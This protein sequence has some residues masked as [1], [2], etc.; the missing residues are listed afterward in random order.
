MTSAARTASLTAE[1]AADRRIRLGRRWTDL[2]RASFLDVDD[3]GVI[4]YHRD[5]S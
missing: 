3:D 2:P 4:T 1:A 5:Y